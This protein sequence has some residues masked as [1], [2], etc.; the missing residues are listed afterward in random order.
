MYL[1]KIEIQGFKSFAKKT[2]LEFDP[3]IISVVGPNGSGKSNFSDAI[4]WVLGEQSMKAVRSKKSEDVIFA[5]SDKKSKLGM[6]EVSITFD[7]TDHK[8]PIDFSEVVIARRLFRDGDSEYLINGQQ[9][10]LMDVAD[11][12]AR[13][14]FGNNSYH[15]ISQG[16]IDQM[17]IA[18]PAA[19]KNLIEEASGVK[20]YYMKRERALRKLEQS[21]NNLVRVADLVA[22]IEPRLRSL[23]RQAKR[24]EQRDQIQTE[25][26]QAQTSFFGVRFRELDSAWKAHADRIARRQEELAAQHGE[27]DSLVQTIQTIEKETEKNS[28]HYAKLQEEIRNEERKKN[29]IQEELAIIRGQLKAGTVPGHTDVR[30]LELKAREI[31]GKIQDTNTL[32]VGLKDRIAL[33]QKNLSHYRKIGEKLAGDIEALKKNL[34]SAQNPFDLKRLHEEIEKVYSRYQSLLYTIRNLNTDDDFHALQEDAANIEIVLVK[35]KDRIADYS[36]VR[37][38]HSEL[39]HLNTQFTKL[40]EQKEKVNEEIHAIQSDIH[41]AESQERFYQQAIA[42]LQSSQERIGRERAKS[43]ASVGDPSWKSLEKEESSLASEL[44]KY[45]AAIEKMETELKSYIHSEATGKKKLL[46]LERTLRSKQDQLGKTKDELGLIQIEKAR[47]EA[48]IEGVISEVRKNLGNEYVEKVRTQPAPNEKDPGLEQKINKLRATL[49]IIGGVDELT[50]QEYKETQERYEY[51]TSQ[52]RDLQKAV[53]DLRQVIIELDGVIKKQFQN[54][55]EKIN[56]HFGEYFRILF[57]GGRAGMT[58]IYQKPEAPPPAED[59]KI[60]EDDQEE[61]SQETP[62]KTTGREEMVG[63]DIKATPPGKKL[64]LLSALS[65]GE[66]TMTA[67]ALLMAMLTAFPSPFVVLDEVDAALDEANSI[68]FSKILSRLSHQTQFITITHNRE[69]MRNSGAL[70]GVTMGED[71][72]SKVLSIKLEK[73]VELAQQL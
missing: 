43:G 4:R 1:K 18:G 16:T 41:I 50:L 2:V 36:N 39:Q 33:G 37:L 67:I 65:G 30:E 3:G 7:N 26:R 27:I 51:L 13:S 71:G 31:E 17:V 66:R 53:N 54:G 5:G 14:G 62:T 72:I 55:Y 10:R 69:T 20:P 15:I 46:E 12:L 42:E 59:Q 34:E 32:V 28:S 47:L 9:V 49:E 68:R 29:Q 56:T 35:L 19:I 38:N 52:S 44:Q 61:I 24:M 58:L 70:Y 48:T 45:F 8:L 57:G 21:G 22:E 11:M 63:I 73:A 40:F 25:L 6:A 23:R 64:A 60:E